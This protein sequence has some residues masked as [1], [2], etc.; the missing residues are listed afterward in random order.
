MVGEIDTF[1]PFTH[2]RG[3]EDAQDLSDLQGHDAG[4]H[5]GVEVLEEDENGWDELDV[6]KGS[7]D[8]ASDDKN[9]N[10]DDESSG[11]NG[12]IGQNLRRDFEKDIVENEMI[13][14]FSERA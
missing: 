12:Q 7:D 3:E 14:F 8:F 6:L 11:K 13:N 2:G 4:Q 9:G 1:S 5:G 10:N